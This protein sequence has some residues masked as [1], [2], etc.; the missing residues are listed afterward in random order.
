MEKNYLEKK[1][2]ED[3]FKE[4]EEYIGDKNKVVDI[5]LVFIIWIFTN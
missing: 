1:L 2:R 3:I 4:V 5:L